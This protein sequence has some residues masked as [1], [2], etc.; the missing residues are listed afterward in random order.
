MKHPITQNPRKVRH[1]DLTVGGGRNPIDG[2]SAELGGFKKLLESRIEVVAPCGPRLI[3]Q[4]PD[5]IAGSKHEKHHLDDRIQCTLYVVPGQREDR[6]RVRQSAPFV[7]SRFLP[8][9]AAEVQLKSLHDHNQAVGSL[10]VTACKKTGL[11]T[12]LLFVVAC[13]PTTGCSSANLGIE[14]NLLRGQSGM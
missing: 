13:H 7:D 10:C 1:V 5:I 12:T 9:G 4:C 14:L 3:A 2:V 8:S 6:R 11:F